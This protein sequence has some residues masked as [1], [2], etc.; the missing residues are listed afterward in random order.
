MICGRTGAPSTEHVIARWI[1]KVLQI[2][3]PVK[4][5]RET[6]Y[7]GRAEALA[8]VLHG[9]CVNCN[10]GWLSYLEKQVQPVLEPILLGAAPG[11][12]RNI[13]PAAQA[14]LAAW[15]V[16]TSLLLALSKFRSEPEGWIPATTLE[17]L[18]SNHR[19]CMAPPGAR[20][21][22][23]GLET[24]DL[25]ASVQAACLYDANGDPIAQCSTFSVGCVLFQV[26][27]CE[28]KDSVLS[29]DNEIWLAAKGLYE[30]ALQQIAPASSPL[31]W[32]PDVV[33]TVPDLKLLAGRL[34]Q[35]L[36]LRT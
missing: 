11:S 21:W 1:R 14:T 13:D 32:P 35:G 4:E 12:V 23:G 3:E 22:I 9:V 30:P 36:P 27:T 34:Q 2:S 24:S 25:P 16:K 7:L 19:L 33:F 18:A 15:A 17:W 28:Q 5:Y 8:V 20:A 29:P 10:N 6:T 26:F 31:R